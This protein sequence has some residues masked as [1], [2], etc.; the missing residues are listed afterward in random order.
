MA[1]IK[2]KPSGGICYQCPECGAE[3]ELGQNYCQECG[4]PFDWRE[5][6]LTEQEAMEALEEM[7]HEKA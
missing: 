4:E 6:F 1:E 2:I 3:I 5:D 7:K